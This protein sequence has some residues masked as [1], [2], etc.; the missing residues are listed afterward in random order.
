[1]GYH[2]ELSK[3]IGMQTPN[4]KLFDLK[5]RVAIVTGAA[6]GIGKEI[7]LAFAEAGAKVVIADM[8]FE[9][10]EAFAE[11]L[12]KQGLKAMALKVDV[13]SENAVQAMVQTT[14][15]KF[16]TI[17]VLVNNAARGGGPASVEALELKDWNSVIAVNLTSV[18]LCCKEVGKAMIEK[19]RGSI[20]NISSIEALVARAYKDE[21]AYGVTKAGVLE[22]TR[23]LAKSWAKYNIRVNAIA[24]GY[25]NTELARLEEGSAKLALIRDRSPM[26]R[27]A[28]PEEFCGPAIFLAADASSYVT[29]H[30][31]V[32]DGG[33]TIV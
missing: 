30:T 2:I 22:L 20:I 31:L 24:P 15:D 26:K 12:G 16:S 32:V 25:A 10:A 7:A 9:A 33:W 6:R 3:V 19:R 14:L 18:F 27:P 1:V 8:A 23:E 29:G 21:A 28:E 5:D 13:A 11:T 4:H 17:D